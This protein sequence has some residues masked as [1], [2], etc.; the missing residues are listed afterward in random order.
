MSVQ[1]L[2]WVLTHSEARLA[3]RLVLIVLA[4]HANP[5][6]GS[7]WPSVATIAHEA[8][9]S[10]RQ[11][12]A[13]LKDLRD[14]GRL[15]VEGDGPKG[16]RIYRVRMEREAEGGAE[17]AG[18]QNRAQ[19]GELFSPEPS[20]TTTVHSRAA[21][22]RAVMEGKPLRLRYKGK[23]VPE[24]RARTACLLVRHFAERTGLAVQCWTPGGDPGESLKRVVGA[25]TA[26]PDVPFERWAEV[27]DACLAS[28]WWEGAPSIGVVFGPRVVEDNL[29]NPGRGGRR[30]E[31][32]AERKLRERNER[33]KARFDR[34]ERSEA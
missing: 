8:R 5:D 12:H 32:A 23:A 30:G 19:G 25:L 18:V 29:L 21:R 1:V 22:E 10:E 28:P 6:G 9:L 33:I 17:S 4:D 11:V 31:T 24:P 15:A 20:L 3:Q 2:T 26:H 16:V 7:A 34:A 14:S 13:A 27:V